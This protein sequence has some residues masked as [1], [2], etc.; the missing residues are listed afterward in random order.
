MKVLPSCMRASSSPSQI[1]ADLRHQP[2]SIDE[3]YFETKRYRVEF[4]GGGKT[5]YILFYVPGGVS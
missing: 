1:T 5:R 2:P 4:A 3:K